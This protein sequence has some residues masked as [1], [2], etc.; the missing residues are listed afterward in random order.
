MSEDCVFCRIVK[1][2]IPCEKIYENNN[3]ISFKDGFPTLEGHSLV[4]S[5]EHFKTLLDFPSDLGNDLIDCMKQT[6]LKLRKEKDFEGFNIL[7]NNF[8][9]AKQVVNHIHFHILPRREGDGFN[10]NL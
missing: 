9:V 1:E 3:F 6:V 8:K 2:E 7:Q 10:F 5:K 4:V